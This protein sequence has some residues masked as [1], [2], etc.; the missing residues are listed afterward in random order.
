MWLLVVVLLNGSEARI[1]PREI[2]SM[3][4]ARSADDP[5]KRYASEV[6][7]VIITTDGHEY[8]T[9][10]ECDAIEGRLKQG[11]HHDLR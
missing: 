10:E 5:M 3:L 2:V 9:R 8:T 4:E 1:N 11:A 6:R 7:C